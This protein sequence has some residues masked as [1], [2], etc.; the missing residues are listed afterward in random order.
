[1]IPAAEFLQLAEACASP[2]PAQT[3]L[4][5]ARTESAL[6]PWALSV[7]RPRRAGASWPGSTARHASRASPVPRPRPCAGPRSSR[8]A[9]SP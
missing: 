7:N 4:A 2:V 9:G 3:L 1:M 5:I 6:H 8:H